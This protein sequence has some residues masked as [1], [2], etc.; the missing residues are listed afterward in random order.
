M[1]RI[2]AVLWTLFI[3]ASSL[4]PTDSLSLPFEG[5]DKI[6]HFAMFVPLGYLLI[7]G[8]SKLA[9]AIAVGVAI[10]LLSEFLQIFVP[11]RSA[12]IFDALADIGGVILGSYVALMRS[13]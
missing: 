5:A 6:I 11:T 12:D 9:I 4:R 1:R 10:A 13:R 7:V 3:I 8:W 2:P